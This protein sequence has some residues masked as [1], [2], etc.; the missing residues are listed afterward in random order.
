MYKPPAEDFI[1]DSFFSFPVYKA[2]SRENELK[3]VTS[4]MAWMRGLRVV[5]IGESELLDHL[6]RWRALATDGQ[7]TSLP[8]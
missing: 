4:K 2:A 8:S 1:Y 5:R 7:L 3:S 6:P